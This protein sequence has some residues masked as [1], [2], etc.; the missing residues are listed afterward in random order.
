MLFQARTRQRDKAV[1]E[2]DAAKEDLQTVQKRIEAHGKRQQI[3]D[4]IAIGDIPDTS[5][6]RDPYARDD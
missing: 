4:D 1:E 6:M 2:R 3:E 5:G